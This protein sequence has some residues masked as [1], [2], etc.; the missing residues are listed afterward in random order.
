MDA[1]IKGFLFSGR[2]DKIEII[3]SAIALTQKPTSTTRMISHLKIRHVTLMEYLELMV[4]R[5]LIKK[6]GQTKT[7]KKT[8]SVYHATEKGLLFL[9]KYHDVW[10][11]LYEKDL[12]KQESMTQP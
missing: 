6:Q 8:A 9:K 1:I 3:A 5:R 4:E 11:V 2:R 12:G 7:A 10:K